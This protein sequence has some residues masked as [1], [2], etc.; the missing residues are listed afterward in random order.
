MLFNSTV[1]FIYLPIVLAVYYCL[2]QRAQNWWLLGAG[3]L[4]YGWWDY[5]FLGLLAISALTDYYCALKI[6]ETSDEPARKRYIVISLVTNLGILGFFKY[7]NFFIDSMKECLAV[8]G[9]DVP[10]PVLNVIL[11]LGISFYTFQALSYTID[12]YR[13]ELRACRNLVDLL[14]FITYFPHLVA[15]PIQRATDLLPQIRGERRVTTSQVRDGLVLML[16]GYFKKVGVADVLAPFVEPRFTSPELCTGPDL[17]ISLY[18]FAIQI[19]CDFSGYS[20]IARGVSKLLGIELK[21]NFN[22]PYL[23]TSITDFWRRWHI[24][25]ST[26]LR[27]YLYIPLGGNRYGTFN[28]YRNLFITMLLGGLWHGAN[29]T[30]VVWGGL[31]GLYLA[32]HKFILDRFGPP[33]TESAGTLGGAVRTFVKILFTFHL[34]CLTWIF[35]RAQNFTTA[36]TY[37]TRIVAWSADGRIEP[38]GWTN[39]ARVAVLIALVLAIDLAQQISGDHVICRGWPPVVRGFAYAVLA[40]AL[41]S[42]GGLDEPSSFIY[43]QF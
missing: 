12:V 35:F 21:L 19:Y 41:F 25:L 7:Y 43:F 26:W 29:W 17:L 38:I 37:L 34:V 31:H 5:R 36:W 8:A 2:S 1:F 28:T 9:L 11:P 10:V 3:L 4:F 15:G 23:A 39:G 22:Q 20:D 18:F 14:L 32:L 33:S 24:S 40:V 42:I 27:D 16:I 6:D 30:F 13:G